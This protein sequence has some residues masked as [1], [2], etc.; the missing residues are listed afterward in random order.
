MVDYQTLVGDVIDNVPGVP[1]VGAKTAAKWLVEYGSLDALVARAGEIKGVVG[2]N[3]RQALGWLPTGR[4]L[5]TIKKDCDL[6]EH[7]GGLPAMEAIAIGAQQTEAL[8]TFYEKYGFKS[9]SRPPESHAVR[10]E[11]VAGL[12]RTRS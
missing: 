1:K 2:E 7:I 9:L 11:P 5:L 6:T 12:R 4:A 10:S 3:L 8:A